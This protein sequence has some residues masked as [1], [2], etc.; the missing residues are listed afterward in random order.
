MPPIAFGLGFAG[1]LPQLAALLALVSG[2]PDWRFVALAA[3]FAYAALILSFL[4]GLWWGIAAANAGR[5]PTWL[6]IASVAPSLIAFASAVPWMI[7]AS[8]PGPSLV[9][10]GGVLVLTLTVDRRIVALGLAPPGWMKL[11]TPLSLGLGVL[12][13]GVAAL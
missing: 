3:A 1:L 9:V 6:W 10:L 7:G 12:T 11:R 13:I 8:W 5:A 2:E 4:G